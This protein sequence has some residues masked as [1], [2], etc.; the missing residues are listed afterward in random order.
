MLLTAGTPHHGAGGEGR[1]LV[2]LHMWEVRGGSWPVRC[3][4][5][6]V[7]HDGTGHAARS[8]AWARKPGYQ[9]RNVSSHSPFNTRVRIC[10][11]R[12]A[13]RLLH[14]IC[15]WKRNKLMC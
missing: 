3:V 9:V 15:C 8:M 4:S 13:P 12:C 1:R 7:W 2:R 14:C 10:S 5:G 6:T 11:R